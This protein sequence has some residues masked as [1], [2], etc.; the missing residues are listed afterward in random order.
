MII[1]NLF[2][3]NTKYFT[4]IQILLSIIL[5]SYVIIFDYSWMWLIAGLFGYFLTGCLG[6]TLTFHRYLSHKSFKLSKF[7]KNSIF[8]L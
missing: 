5:L 3:A 4:T 8:R 7:F 6:I 1:K 2:V